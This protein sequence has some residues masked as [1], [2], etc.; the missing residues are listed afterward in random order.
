VD[1]TYAVPGYTWSTGNNS[2]HKKVSAGYLVAKGRRA[3]VTW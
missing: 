3:T 2:G 1:A